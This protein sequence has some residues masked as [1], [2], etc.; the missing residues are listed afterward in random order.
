MLSLP[1]FHVT[2]EDRRSGSNWHLLLAPWVLP[3]FPGNAAVSVK[4]TV[5]GHSWA[6][7]ALCRTPVVAMGYLSAFP[8]LQ[9]GGFPALLHLVLL[10]VSSGTL[11][12]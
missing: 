5:L 7:P 9:H 6:C 2:L 3:V 8:E 10:L 12:S 4:A 11:F 1:I